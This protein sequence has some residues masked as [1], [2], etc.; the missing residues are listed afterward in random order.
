MYSH[1]YVRL[2]GGPR[3]HDLPVLFR[4]RELLEAFEHTQLIQVKSRT[5]WSCHF[6]SSANPTCFYLDFILVLLYYC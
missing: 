2:T 5:V 4:D 6:S 3:L 1:C